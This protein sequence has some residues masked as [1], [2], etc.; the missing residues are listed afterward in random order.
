VNERDEQVE[1]RQTEESWYDQNP[2][3]RLYHVLLEDD[4]QK[5]CGQRH[6]TPLRD[7]FDAR[8][9]DAQPATLYE[10][11]AEQFNSPNF[12]PATNVYPDLHSF[13]A[14]SI[15]LPVHIAPMPVTPKK[16]KDK[17][18]EVHSHLVRVSTSVYCVTVSY[19]HHCSNYSKQLHTAD[20]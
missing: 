14:Q 18:A 12:N 19:K 6:D 16:I 17:F 4:V 2:F 1:Q 8:N 3:L 15:Q 7:G 5:A 10:V 11:L 9:C 13:F 20:C